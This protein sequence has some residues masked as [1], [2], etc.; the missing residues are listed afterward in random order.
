[1][2]LR[3]VIISGNSGRAMRSTGVGHWPSADILRFA[4]DD[5]LPLAVPF[6]YFASF[7]RK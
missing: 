7:A 6:G 5:K 2:I 4:L 1:M 3:W